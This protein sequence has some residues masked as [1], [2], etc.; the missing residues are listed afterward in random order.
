MADREDSSVYHEIYT[1][2]IQALPLFPEHRASLKA[3]R[4]FSDE[5]IDRLR[6]RSCAPQLEGDITANLAETFP[7]RELR[8][9]GVFVND[10]L[11]PKLTQDNILIPFMDGD[12]VIQIKPHKNS[13]AGFGLKPYIPAPLKSFCIIAESEFKAA[14]ALQLGYSA[15]GISGVTSFSGKNFPALVEKLTASAVTTICI[16]FD[17]EIKDDPTLPNYK[18]YFWERYDTQYFSWLFA[19]KLEE[20]GFETTIATL[21]DAWRVNGKIDIDGALAMG[22]TKEAFDPVVKSRLSPHDYLKSFPADVQHLM[23][24]LWMRNHVNFPVRAAD[25]RYLAPRGK[26][27]DLTE[28]PIS[29]FTMAID[30]SIYGA[31]GE[32][33]REVTLENDVGDV[34]PRAIL[35][36]DHISHYLGFRKRCLSLGNFQFTGAQKDLEALMGYETSREVGKKIYQPDHVG[37]CRG[38]EI[39]LYDNCAVTRQGERR[40]VDE[41]GVIWLGLTGFQ[42]VSLTQGGEDARANIPRLWHEDLDPGTLINEIERNFGGDKGIRLACAWLVA[43][44]FSHELSQLYG[45]AFPLLFIS[46]QQES[47][48][49]TLARWLSAMSGITT[50]GNSY[51]SGTLVG[52]QRSLGYYSSLPLWLDEYRNSTENSV[53]A[54]EGFLRSAYDGQTS[55]KGLR[56]NFGVRGPT[57]RGRLIISGQDTPNDQALLQRCVTIRMQG[58]NKTGQ[59]YL[60][61]NGR[62]ETFSGIIPTLIKRFHENKAETIKAIHVMREHLRKQK[63]DDRTA[64]TYGI[65]AGCYD[66]IIQANDKRFLDYCVKHAKESFASKEAEKPY[67]SLL[68]GIQ[69]LKQQGQLNGNM[70]RATSEGLAIYTDGVIGAW[71]KEMRRRGEEFPFKNVTII[72]EFEECGWLVA[73]KQV[74]IKGQNLMCVILRTTDDQVR[75]IYDAA[76][77]EEK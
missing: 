62:T 19:R 67:R 53:R 75:T 48:K 73:H 40:A 3:K 37:W 17:N 51:W 14:A 26:G 13:F 42:A 23:Q 60:A 66:G 45:S 18:P 31:D 64:I 7:V 72:N 34:C 55:L 30:A 68:N 28:V 71:R 2:L 46:G 49:S 6:F 63:L 56:Q 35:E 44:L 77:A 21:P 15:L 38:G 57:V 22:K 8:A 9:A 20:A 16:I 27:D 70:I 41:D 29:N 59:D 36:A 39:Y 61:L 10:Q 4:G 24:R 1:A 25:G 58:R 65:V 54:K 11:N 5:T 47:G 74:K 69:D 43:T 12:R 32:C 52:F 50:E 33:R 76:D